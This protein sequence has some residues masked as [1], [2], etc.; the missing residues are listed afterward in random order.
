VPVLLASGESGTPIKLR[1]ST[2]DA[3]C[4]ALPDHESRRRGEED[5]D[6]VEFAVEPT[7]ELEVPRL[8]SPNAHRTLLVMHLDVCRDEVF[9]GCSASVDK[10][11]SFVSSLSIAV[12]RSSICV[13]RRSSVRDARKLSRRLKRAIEGGTG[14]SRTASARMRSLRIHRHTLSR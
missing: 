14:A 10:L 8:L 5:G 9:C 2:H 12:S 3:F 13:V 11:R 1:L 6:P 4:Q 7:E